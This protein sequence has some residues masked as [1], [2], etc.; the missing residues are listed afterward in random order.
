[1]VI[2]IGITCIIQNS[3]SLLI[4][5]RFMVSKIKY[6]GCFLLLVLAAS[7]SQSVPEE[8]TSSDDKIEIYPDYS[9]IVIPNNIAPMN[10]RIIEETDDYLTKVSDEKGNSIIVSGR[11][12]SFSKSKWAKLLDDNKGGDLKYEIYLNKDGKWQQYTFTNTIA[13]DPI[14]EY[15][16]YRLIEPSYSLYKKL[17]INQRNLTSFN[18]SKIYSSPVKWQC[19][20]CHSYQDYNKTGNMNLHLR[21]P[22]G[23]TII[24]NK[25]KVEK[26]NL[27][28]EEL[29]KGGAYV[30]WHPT[31]NL[32][33][34]SINKVGQTF[35]SKDIQKVEVMDSFSDLILYDVDK[36]EVRYIVQSKDYL[37]TYPCWAP[38]GKTLYFSSA[39]F[40]AVSDDEYKLDKINELYQNVKYN[41]YKVSFNPETLEFGKPTLVFNAVARGKSATFPKLSPDGRYLMFTMA[42]YGCFHI[43]HKSADLYVMD[44]EKGRV[45]R[46]DEVNSDDVES[47][48]SWSSN[49]RW[50]IFS[51]RRDD[52]SYTRFYISYFDKNGK[53]HKPFILP[54]EYTG[55]YKEFFKSYNIPEFMVEPVEYSY[56]DFAI[57]GPAKQAKFVEK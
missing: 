47:Y 29:P 31:K 56:R 9:Q 25:G 54:Q 32:I 52:G 46:L 53:A 48:H 8:F 23:G 20:N 34:Y 35:H 12:V 41:I 7:C 22:E 39:H 55:F 21:G 13:A 57:E 49:G 10:F 38:D 37:E 2:R 42:D 16:S 14:D 3:N 43:W 6:L 30:S 11:E 18:E 45:Q 24:T 5:M 44:L 15:I 40:K 51:S 36:N 33:A 50:F 4:V 19:M 26:V 28:T 27:K 17:S 1:M